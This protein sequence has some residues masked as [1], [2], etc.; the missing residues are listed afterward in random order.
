M[1][2]PAQSPDLNPIKRCWNELDSRVKAKQPTSA[3]HL[4]ELLQ[5]CWEE[6][7]EQYLISVVK[8]MPQVCS[9]VI[10]T[11]DV[12]TLRS[13]RFRLHFLKGNDSIISLSNYLFILWEYI[14][15]LN[16][17]NKKNQI[18]GCSKTFHQ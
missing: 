10:S 14:E 18:W 6:L 5:H 7:T 2:G 1:E 12:A 16:C 4:W 3:T 15:I 9:A 8:G 13:Q 17:L 11:K